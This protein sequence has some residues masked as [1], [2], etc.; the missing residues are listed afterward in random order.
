GWRVTS[1]NVTRD[2]SKPPPYHRF[3]TLGQLKNK[4]RDNSAEWFDL[5]HKPQANMASNR[6]PRSLKVAVATLKNFNLITIRIGDEKE[7]GNDFAIG[8]K[9]NQHARGK[10]RSTHARVFGINIIDRNR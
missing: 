10:P 4:I 8:G 2:A 1:E 5:S 7:T 9:V 3:A 6:W